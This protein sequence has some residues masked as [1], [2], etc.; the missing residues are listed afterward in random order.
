MTEN[1]IQ[2][3]EMSGTTA[4]HHA[5]TPRR[6]LHLSLVMGAFL[7]F[8]FSWYQAAGLTLLILLLELVILPDMGLELQKTTGWGKYAREEISRPGLVLY[9]LALLILVLIFYGHLGVVAAAWGVMALGDVTAGIA[10]E[11]WGRLRLPF[12]FAKSWAGFLSFIGFGAAGAFVLLLWVNTSMSSQKALGIAIAAAIAGALVE[13]LPIRLDDNITVPVVAAGL[14]FCAGLIARVSFDENLPFLGIRIILA[15]VINAAFA[16]LAWQLRQITLSGAAVGFFLG[17]AI[18]MG[19]GYKSFLILLGFFVL[20]SVTTRLGY[21]TKLKRGIAERRGGARS[22]K[23]AV[24]NLLPAAWFSILVI[25]TPYQ[26]AFLMAVVAALAEAAGDTVASETGKWLSSKAWLITT[27]K[28]VPAGEDG[29]ITLRG[30]AA[31]IVASALIVLLGYGLNLMRG[32]NI[33]V[34]L[35]AAVAGN[36]ADSVLGAT[37]ERRGLVTNAVVNFAGTGFA[38]TLALGFALHHR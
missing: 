17:V 8:S 1:T 9:P 28:P 15:I 33:V 19:F 3:S 2:D 22:W 27:L 32:W 24:G 13:S 4:R 37:L 23:E 29:G 11:R 26:P 18:Y 36:L 14:I 31:G 20:G 30:T 12:N 6:I 7:L 38:G 5:W 16:L 25:T 34:V 21:E 35:L 10:G